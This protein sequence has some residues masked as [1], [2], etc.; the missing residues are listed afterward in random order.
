MAI[1]HLDENSKQ[2]SS[3]ENGGKSKLDTSPQTGDKSKQET[4]RHLL[5]QRLKALKF[6]WNLMPMANQNQVRQRW[7]QARSKF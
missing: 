4:L 2:D 3:L 5:M 1:I 6:L 7:K